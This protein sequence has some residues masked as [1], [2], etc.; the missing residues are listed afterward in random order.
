M[1]KDSSI[2]NYLIA[3]GVLF[4]VFLIPRLFVAGNKKKKTRRDRY[5]P[6][7]PDPRIAERI[8]RPREKSHTVYDTPYEWPAGPGDEKGARAQAGSPGAKKRRR[9]GPTPLEEGG[10]VA[11][12]MVTERAQPAPPPKKLPVYSGNPV[13]NG[14]IWA[15]ILTRRGTGR[16][17]M[18]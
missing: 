15:E 12:V 10:P 3:A 4:F 1:P 9:S 17:G 11:R 13:V 16:R 14:V 5:A 6:A 7:P 18:R 8:K 2:V